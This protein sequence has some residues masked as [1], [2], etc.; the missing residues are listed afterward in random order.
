MCIFKI[1]SDDTHFASPT[2]SFFNSHHAFH[3]LNTPTAPLVTFFLVQK[4]HPQY[5]LLS[6]LALAHR[7]DIHG[8]VGTMARPTGT[9][10]PEKHHGVQGL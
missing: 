4:S 2:D 6:F 10:L 8:E 5:D 9:Q 1:F 3:L 7:L